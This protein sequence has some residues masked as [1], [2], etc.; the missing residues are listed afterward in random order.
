MRLIGPLP[1]VFER[2]KC[3]KGLTPRGVDHGPVCIDSTCCHASTDVLQ[4]VMDVIPRS[5]DTVIFPNYESMPERDDVED[6][7]MEARP[8]ACPYSFQSYSIV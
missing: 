5:V 6:S 8:A 1:A 7:F 2:C 4:A 3:H